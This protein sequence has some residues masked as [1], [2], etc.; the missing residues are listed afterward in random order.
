MPPEL[1]TNR[2][3]TVEQVSDEL[4]VSVAQIRA[5]LRNGDLRGI[6]LGGRNVWRIGLVDLED[7]IAE[8]YRRT[9]QRIANGDVEH[10]GLGG[11]S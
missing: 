3:L 9:A 2:F 1:K 8:A 6:Q 5:L 7:Y 4:N 11:H 10:G